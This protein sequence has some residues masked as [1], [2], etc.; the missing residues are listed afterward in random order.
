MDNLDNHHASVNQLAILIFYFVLIGLIT[1][2]SY[3]QD[4]LEF[5]RWLVQV[6]L[7]SL[8][9]G[10]FVFM[11]SKYPKLSAQRGVLLAFS[12]GVMTIIPAVLMSLSFPDEFWTQYATI[13]LSMAA[14]SLLGFI[15]IELSSRYLDR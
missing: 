14:A 3:L 1:I 5:N 11:G 7:I 15:F 12:I 4:T 9:V 6:L 2:L 8:G 13:G 10:V